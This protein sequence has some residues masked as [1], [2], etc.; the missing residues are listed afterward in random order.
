MT[1][2]TI[3]MS[4]IDD[5]KLS[6]MVEDAVRRFE[7]GD[8]GTGEHAVVVM[9]TFEEAARRWLIDN[10]VGHR[11]DPLT[12]SALRAIG[13]VNGCTKRW[14]LQLGILYIA[15]PYSSMTDYWAGVRASPTGDFVPIPCPKTMG[16]LQSTLMALGL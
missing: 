8:Y 7:Y 15:L 6:E 1:D 4:D 5:G 13:F 9:A 11:N 10:K 3:S 16:Q 12:E 2:K 14:T